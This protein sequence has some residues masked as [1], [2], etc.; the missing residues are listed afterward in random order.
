SANRASRAQPGISEASRQ[1]VPSALRRIVGGP[2]T[3]SDRNRPS[4]MRKYALALVIIP[5]LSFAA[6]PSL[7]VPDGRS[8]IGRTLLQFEGET[9]LVWY[10]A[11]KALSTSE[12]LTPQS[13][14]EIQ[15]SDGY[16]EQSPET[17]R[18]W[19]QIRT[20]AGDNAPIADGRYPLIVFLPG[21]GVFGF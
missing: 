5:V 11:S 17:I 10:P 14:A 8:H 19:T 15:A 18:S 7:P 21:A 6:V 1:N 13:A 4:T 2:L 16:Y 12:Y 20:N 3:P 9:V